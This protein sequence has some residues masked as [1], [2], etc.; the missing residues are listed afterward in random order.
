MVRPTLGLSCLFLF[1]ISLVVIL[2]ARVVLPPN[3]TVP[4]IIG[5]GDSIIDPGN[6]NQVATIAKCNFPPYGR[7]FMGGR[8]TG[9][10]TNGRNPTD[11]IV[12]EL[13]VK[14]YLPAYLDPDLKP[15]ELLTGVCFA[16]GGAGYDPVTSALG[17]GIPLSEQLNMFK[18][19]IGKLRAM[20]G[21][22][23]TDFI[24]SNSVYVVVF[25]SNDIANTYFGPIPIR[26]AHYDYNSYS[27]LILTYASS[28]FKELHSLGARRMA[29][30]GAPP[31][32]CVP[33]QRTV[34]GGPS[35]ECVA[36]QL[37]FST[38]YNSKLKSLLQSLGP[39]LPESRLV[40]IDIYYSLLDIILNPSKYDIEEV[41]RGCCGTGLI[42]VTQLCNKFDRL[43]PDDTKYLFWDSYH[44]TERGYQIVVATLSKYVNA[45]L[46]SRNSYSLIV[47]LISISL[48][49][50]IDARTIL[51]PNVTVPAIIGFGD[52]IIDPG[53]NNNIATLVKCNFPPY[54]KDFTYGPTGRFSNGRIPTDIV[55]DELGVKR[56]LP[57][58]TDP[59]L[60]PEEL[61]TGVSFASGASGYDPLTSSIAS[62]ISLSE[63]LN[64]FREY[65]EKLMAMAGPEKTDFIISNSM[66]LVIAGSDDIANTYFDTPIRRKDY[67]FNTYTDLMLSS[68]SSFV[69]ELY[70]VGA[71]RIAVFG[72]PP[73][74]C[75]PSQR[76]I[77][78]GPYRMCADDYNR[79]AV[80][81]N[82]KLS[83]QLT[84]LQASLPGSKI[85]YVDVYTPLLDMILSP[86]KYGLEV[87]TKGCCG[88][89]LIEVSVLC[90]KLDPVCPDDSNY[91]FW[92]SYHPTEK[93]YT[94][95]TGIILDKY[96]DDLI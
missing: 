28:L 81:F 38:L 57:A 18:E 88:T 31:L 58:Y 47:L 85:V 43:C 13:G 63:Q 46:V 69:Q 90:N 11:L 53:N 27:D 26:K 32:G 22:E 1:V 96:V 20:V 3:V 37:Q 29:I 77:G 5:F 4:A 70:G 56:Y 49:L 9:R 33:S 44:P 61:L 50:A 45:L 10:F 41:T 65:K 75:V 84:S 52:S 59:N 95:L 12:E 35:R 80:L 66:Y 8:P 89:G 16:S 15:Q 94:I 54:G 7:D 34:S 23:R 14:N 67:D 30:F 92:D 48:L 68:A 71:R 91:L 73:I 82:S 17:T 62:V 74:G 24:I 79:V 60:N 87:V 83:P 86:T 64:M 36:D 19:Y 2:D 42:E 76:T 21:P 25:G 51:P 78:G 40:Y 39:T 6:N 93:G 72:A 55:A